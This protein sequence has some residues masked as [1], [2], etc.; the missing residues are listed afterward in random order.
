M[1][2]DKFPHVNP[3]DTRREYLNMEWTTDFVIRTADGR[4]TIRE[5][6]DLKDFAKKAV[7]EK[8]ELSRR[9][10]AVLDILDWKLIV[11]GET[12]RKQKEE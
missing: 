1:A 8:L 5:F 10:W 11:C 3:V 6:V 7:I 4:S 9:Y 2:L 12:T